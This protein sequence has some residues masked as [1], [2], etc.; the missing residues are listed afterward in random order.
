MEVSINGIWGSVCDDHWSLEDAKVVCGMLGL[1]QA[2][3]AT[4]GKSFGRGTGPVWLDDVKC[5]GNETSLMFCPKADLGVKDCAHF[6]DAGVV[7]GLPTS[8]SL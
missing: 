2:T 5:V 7:C 1:P 4:L 8:E 6:E 3:A